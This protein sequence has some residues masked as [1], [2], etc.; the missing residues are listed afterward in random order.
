MG[1]EPGTV[2]LYPGS[3]DHTS[4]VCWL[5]Q[6]FSNHALRDR[7]LR[8]RHPGPP[9]GWAEAEGPVPTPVSPRANSTSVC[10]IYRGLYE[11]S[12]E[13]KISLLSRRVESSAASVAPKS[14]FVQGRLCVLT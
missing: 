12:L 5:S 9:E 1:F 3:G 10:L 13:P 4:Q 7:D 14:P 11:I 6:W 8:Q 2:C